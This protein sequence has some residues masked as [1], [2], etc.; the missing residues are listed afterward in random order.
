VHR[1]ESES[2]EI[3]FLTKLSNMY[4]ACISVDAFQTDNAS[5]L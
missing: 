5:D 3:P 2:Q 4:F 1:N